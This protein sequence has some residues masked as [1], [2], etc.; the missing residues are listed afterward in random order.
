MDLLDWT[1]IIIGGIIAI[2]F[3]VLFLT[4]EKK[5]KGKD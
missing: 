1:Y 3:L 5:N 2:M 4:S